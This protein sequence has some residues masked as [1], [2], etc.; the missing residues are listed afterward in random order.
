MKTRTLAYSCAV[1]LVLMSAPA[2]IHAQVA[3]FTIEP[4]TSLAWWQIDPNYGHLWATTCPDD[5][6]WQPGEARSSNSKVN[7]AT[8]KAT[9]ASHHSD[10]RVPIY[11]RGD[12]SPVCRR[13]V[14]GTITVADASQW[15]DVRGE[16][17]VL[18][19]SL[20]TGL[21]LRDKFARKSVLETHKYREIK[22]TIDS[23]T[24][25]QAGDTITA[26]AVGTFELHGRTSELTAP[27]KAWRE[28]GALRVIT[29]FSF[30][31]PELTRAYS[32]S[33]M[34]L[35]MGVTLGRWKTV[36]VGIDVMLQET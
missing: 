8:R 35:G 27:V 30:P 6:S 25:V 4:A 15:R 12:V 3:R 31:A 1:A 28:N 23:L 29:I 2:Q 20:M 14:S 22:F 10:S 19:D 36:H 17:R 18:G 26:V 32:M 34:A 7:L 13:A 16:V 11:P 9:I 33:K 24:N 5:P 21:D